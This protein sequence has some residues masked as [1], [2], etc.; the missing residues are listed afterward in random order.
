[1]RAW[2]V[3]LAFAVQA[4]IVAP[5]FA[6]PLEVLKLQSEHPVDGMVGGNLSGLALCNGRL[7]T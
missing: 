2:L 3:A 1:M 6:A 4:L 7:W 5:V